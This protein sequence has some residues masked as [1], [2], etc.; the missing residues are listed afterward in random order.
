M[1]AASPHEHHDHDFRTVGG[2]VG[3]EPADPGARPGLARH[4]HVR[5]ERARGAAFVDRAQ[6]AVREP[7]QHGARGKAPALV[8]GEAVGP[9]HLRLVDDAAV[10]GGGE[11]HGQL[12]G[13]RRHAR[14]VARE[15]A[16]LAGPDRHRDRPRGLALEV[17]AGRAAQAQQLRV[18][19]D[20]LVA[21]ALAHPLEIGVAGLGQRLAQVHDAMAG[22]DPA[23]AG[24]VV[25]RLRRDHAFREPRHRHHDLEDG[26]GLVGGG[27]PALRVDERHHAPGVGVHRHYGAR[28]ALEAA[29]ARLPD[30]EV[31]RRRRGRNDE[32][33]QR[34]R[35]RP[36]PRR[37][38]AARGAG[39]GGVGDR[40]RGQ[41]EG[42]GQAE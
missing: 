13:G 37:A 35:A 4:D 23:P 8:G 22:P 3:G 31:T 29:P 42:E 15:M 36:R 24:A 12:Y 32:G 6:E 20:A 7:A 28:R 18:V 39:W 1:S 5:I 14:G 9:A 41:A 2:R 34:R 26:A 11:K 17:D 16:D 25:R 10:H 27:H 30:L 38:A 19:V 40:I 33:R 21:Q